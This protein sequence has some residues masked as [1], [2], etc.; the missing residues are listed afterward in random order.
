MRAYQGINL[1]AYHPLFPRKKAIYRNYLIQNN[2]LA[3]NPLFSRER[4]WEAGNNLT[5]DGFCKSTVS[6]L[7]VGSGEPLTALSFFQTKTSF[8][9]GS[10]K[11]GTH[12]LTNR[13]HLAGEAQYCERMRCLACAAMNSGPNPRGVLCSETVWPQGSVSQMTPSAG[14]GD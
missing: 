4:C 14:E 11:Q 3:L 2:Y 12:I 10:T 7:N 9:F 6:M 8:S 13:Y 1:F 5:R